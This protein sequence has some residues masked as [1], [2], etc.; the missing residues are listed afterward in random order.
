VTTIV[1]APDSFKGT[2][3]AREASA[4][5]AR[6]WSSVR[7]D[8][9]LVLRPMADGG[10]G[11]L[12]A[13]A[14]ATPGA[15][16]MPAT[17]IGPDNHDVHAEWLLLPEG[18]AVVELATASGLHLL[19]PLLPR[20]AH[21]LG[22]GQL[23]D[24]ACD[25]GATRLVLGIGGSASTDGGVGLLT[26]L[27][28]A[29][30][31]SRGDPIPLGNRGLASLETV[32]LSGLR[33]A[34]AGSIA[35]TDV[36]NPMLGRRGAAQVFGP[37]KG[38]A[39]SDLEELDVNLTRLADVLD[40]RS[41]AAES[42]TGAAGGAGF[43]L[44]VWGVALAAGARTVGELVGLPAA[45]KSA[46]LVI[47]GEGRY[48]DQTASGKVA[49]YVVSL[50]DASRVP[51]AL[52]AGEIDARTDAFRDV[53]SLASLAGSTSSARSDA[54]HWLVEAGAQL[55]RGFVSRPS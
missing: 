8:D 51:A 27:G 10:E 17:V 26:A 35:L 12:E 15:I 52:V 25:A 19:D 39:Q 23:I 33:T 30:L 54:E 40:L 42:G 53:V 47:T 5:I 37:Q 4:A 38:A 9:E 6:G 49:H 13:F 45:L 7:G 34:P 1:I 24:A 11:T 46:Q 44:E 55:A 2:V 3:G 48:D 16:R 28:A 50:A 29:F 43:A 20:D 31:D 41:L 18:T 32:D 22:F 36:T 21:T 14:T